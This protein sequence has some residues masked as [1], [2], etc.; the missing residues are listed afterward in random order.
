[1]VDRMGW[2]KYFMDMAV[3]AACR[4]TCIRRQVGAVLVKDNRVLCTGYN[5]APAGAPHCDEVGC[6]RAQLDVPSGE[7]HELCRGLHAEQNII[8]QAAR[9]GVSIHGGTLYCTTYPCS[10]CAK[11]LVNSGVTQIFILHDYPDPTAREILSAG[12]LPIEKICT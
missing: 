7:K 12:D 3:L 8:I 4:S 6:I 5:G 11:M 10:I 2:N 9:F 1:M